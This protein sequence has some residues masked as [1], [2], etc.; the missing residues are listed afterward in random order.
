MIDFKKLSKPRSSSFI[1]N[2]SDFTKPKDHQTPTPDLHPFTRKQL[3]NQLYYEEY[4]TMDISAFD[5]NSFLDATTS[6]V[7]TKRPLIPVGRDVI[8]TIGEPKSIPWTS[9]KDGI[10]RQGMRIDVP[11][12]FDVASFPPDIQQLYMVDGKLTTTK[13]VITDGVMLDLT[14]Q[15]AIDGAPGKNARQ[16]QY[17]DALDLNKP[18]DRFNWRMVQGRQIRVKIRHEPYNNEVY[19]KIGAV[20]KV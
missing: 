11:F 13:I 14:E 6:E 12:E 9:N 16:R 3:I 19:D 20:A 18:G 1:D 10:P 7:Q 5:P 15:G 4:Q 8:A 17:R 2:L